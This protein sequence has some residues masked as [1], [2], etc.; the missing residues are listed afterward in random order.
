MNHIKTISKR[1]DSRKCITDGKKGG[2]NDTQFDQWWNI[3]E[4]LHNTQQKAAIL[5]WN[6]AGKTLLAILLLQNVNQGSW[7]YPKYVGGTVVKGKQIIT[8]SFGGVQESE[9][10]E[11]QKI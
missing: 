10:S 2:K 1:S 7:E 5:G 4:T 6:S 9:L 8:M 11:I 3:R